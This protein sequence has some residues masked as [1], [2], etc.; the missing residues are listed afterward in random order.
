MPNPTPVL[1]RLSAAVLA[2]ATILLPAAPAHAQF[3]R[4]GGMMGG[5]WDEPT[6]SSKEI[7]RYAEIIKL[8]PDQ[9]ENAKG[10][11]EG[12]NTEYNAIRQDMRKA[13]EAMRD[14]AR[15]T[16]DNSIWRDAGKMMQGF[17][18]KVTKLETQY[19]DDVKLLL[20]E[21]QAAKWPAVERARR[22]E[23]SVPRGGLLSGESVDLVKIVTSD[24]KLKPEEI[25]PVQP[26]LDQ[27][28]TELDR[29]LAERDKAYEE[30]TSQ[31]ANLFFTQQMDKVEEL[32]TKARDAAAK[33][34]EVNKRYAR[35][36]E[37][38]LPEAR[39]AEFQKEVQKASFPRVYRPTYVTRSID[40]ALGLQDLTTEQKTRIA[41]I[42]TNFE[43]QIAP[44]QEKQA[45]S[46][47]STEMSRTAMQMMGMG[48]PGG[49]NEG[50][51]E[52]RDAR[53]EL[54]EGTFD[55][56]KNVLTPEQAGKLPERPQRGNWRN[57]VPGM[58]GGGGAGG[59]ERPRRNQN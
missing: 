43:Q 12:F 55:K 14:E 20:N 4:G 15:D 11:L 30:G 32:F 34:K 9:L 25:V 53:R 50:S 49:G 2:A 16:G 24:L 19:F 52:L 42:K 10:M 7:E 29:V 54:E 33:V 17:Q 44:L 28:E 46:I 31:G 40:T 26:L 59:G 58:G 13:F 8:T 48:G 22:R 18:A 51:A 36:I 27:Y 21:D 57:M 23:K 47:E 56:I 38:G 41:E 45:A 6:I 39:H 37:A 3:G 35:Q 5:N 1:V